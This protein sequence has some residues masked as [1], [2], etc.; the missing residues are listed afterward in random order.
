M[1]MSRRGER[2]SCGPV[3]SGKSGQAVLARAAASAI[4]ALEQR[5]LLSG[6]PQPVDPALHDALSGFLQSEF[7]KATDADVDTLLGRGARPINWQGRTELARQGEWII[8][9]PES[10]VGK[11]G[12]IRKARESLDRHR[13]KAM[14][15]LD[16]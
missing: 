13:A 5:V 16:E 6:D 7:G 4:E 2:G 10:E 8:R 9:L 3:R 12:S 11:G 15:K 1:S 14:A